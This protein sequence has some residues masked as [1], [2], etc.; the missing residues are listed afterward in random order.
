MAQLLIDT[1]FGLA[2]KSAALSSTTILVPKS[3]E[4]GDGWQLGSDHVIARRC[5]CRRR[6]WPPWP[7]S[8]EVG[9]V[10]TLGQTPT[11]P[12][13]A[14]RLW[15]HAVKLLDL[16]P[17]SGLKL[18]AQPGQPPLLASRCQPAILHHTHR[19]VLAALLYCAGAG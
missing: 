17:C 12:Q 2:F 5:S 14:E 11:L 16:L 1:I 7:V 10:D 15:P 4:R 8:L 6:C 3:V 9:A 19:Y 13:R 18:P